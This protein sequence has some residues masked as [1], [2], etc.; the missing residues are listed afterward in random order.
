MKDIKHRRITRKEHI[1]TVLSI[2]MSSRESQRKNRGEPGLMAI[3]RKQEKNA[4]NTINDVPI[5]V[6]VEEQESWSRGM[7]G[8]GG[9]ATLHHD[10]DDD[11][12]EHNVNKPLAIRMRPS[13]LDDVIGQDE[14]LAPGSPLRRLAVPVDQSMSVAPSAII[15]YG[16]PGV[17]KKTLAKI[18]AR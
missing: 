13:T 15:L 5:P 7:R 17:G 1:L 4:S 9:R 2:T 3:M 10:T 8:D 14:A 16:P 18:V 12:D 11:T 6:S